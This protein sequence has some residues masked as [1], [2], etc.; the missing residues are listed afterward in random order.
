MSLEFI[1][2]WKNRI[3]LLAA[4]FCVFAVICVIDGGVSYLREPFNTLR[5]FPGDTYSLTGPLAPGASSPDQMTIESD[6]HSLTISIE[7]IISGFWLGGKM[8]R[9]TLR[10]DPRIEPGRYV[11]SVFGKE[12]QKKVGSNVFQVLVYADRTSYLADSKSLFLRNTGVSPWEFTGAFFA[13]VVLCCVCLYFISGKRDMLMAENG[14]AEV[15]H[16]VADEP[17]FSVYFGL[18]ERN[19]LKQGDRLVLMDPSGKVVEEVSVESVSEKD[20][21][22]RVSPL[23]SVRPGYF[24][25][26][27]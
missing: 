16:V 8:W 3:A 22:V 14:E 13:L 27:V 21:S 23:S 7:E 25:K 4:A 11:V 20:A 5:L 26:R 15:Y 12:D 9:G 18:G 6:S 10:L 2:R 1:S 17:G 24:V 19:G